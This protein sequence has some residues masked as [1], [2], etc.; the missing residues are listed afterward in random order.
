[1]SAAIDLPTTSSSLLDIDLF[2]SFTEGEDTNMTY[3]WTNQPLAALEPLDNLLNRL[4]PQSLSH[5][6]PEEDISAA[7]LSTLHSHYFDSFYFSI[8][9]LNRDRFLAESTGGGG[10][11][12]SALVY[13]VALAGCAHSSKDPNRQST[14]Y[15]LA[16]N[17]AEKCE[18]DGGL[19]DINFVQALLFIG[20]F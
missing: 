7:E 9:F 19:N 13:A 10:P 18:R 4:S 11:A 5:S 20:R 12:V 3:D 2:T 1:M 17:Y 6:G 8:P 16:R 14:C 15:S